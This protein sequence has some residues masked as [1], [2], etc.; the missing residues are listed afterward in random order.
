MFETRLF[1]VAG[2]AFA[3]RIAATVFAPAG[4]AR[5]SVLA[6]H[7][8][9]RQKR[10]FDDMAA[11]LAR[12]GYCV[13]CVDVPGR[14]GSSWLPG[15]QDYT[16]ETYARVLCALI[17]Q[18]GWGPVHWVGSSMGG[19]I[20]LAL[21]DIGR[22]DAARSLT[23]VDVTHK[24]NA[25]A[26]A[27]IAAYLPDTLPVI[28][29]RAAYLAF[30]KRNLPLGPVGEEVWARF[31]DHQLV[32]VPG[33]YVAHFDPNIVPLARQALAEGIDLT[34][35]ARALPCPVALVAGEVSDLCGAREIAELEALRPGLPVFICPGAGHI[36]A[37]ADED[38]AAFIA[39]FIAQAEAAA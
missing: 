1:D 23:L 16:L 15:P 22:A 12:A 14:G 29:D 28:S 26:C 20:A 36:P 31:A 8:L 11:H 30:V 4:V 27:R 9:S 33:G 10:D 17:D 37:L 38:S 7:G 2:L 34:Q 32:P 18:Q 19:L 35:G 13:Y 39:G 6:V 25:D 21:S 3:C 24:P 5:G